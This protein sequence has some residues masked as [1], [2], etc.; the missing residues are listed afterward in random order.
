MPTAKIFGGGQLSTNTTNVRARVS[1][2]REKP[3]LS[4][5]KGSWMAFP[6]LRFAA[7]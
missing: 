4:L 1:F 3:A 5:S 7:L 2:I 6:N